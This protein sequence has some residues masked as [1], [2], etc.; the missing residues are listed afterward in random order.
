M[1]FLSFREVE[2]IFHKKQMEVIAQK[3]VPFKAFR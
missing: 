2:D 3:Q 1:H